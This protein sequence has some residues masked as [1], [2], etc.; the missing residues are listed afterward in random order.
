MFAGEVYG[1]SGC[2]STS[3]FGFPFCMHR[4]ICRSDRGVQRGRSLPVRLNDSDEIVNVL[5]HG[6]FCHLRLARDDRVHD[7][8]M[9]VSERE[10]GS[11][12][13]RDEVEEGRESIVA[14]IKGQ[15][16]DRGQHLV[17]GGFR[18]QAVK[19]DRDR[20]MIRSLG[21]VMDMRICHRAHRNTFLVSRTQCRVPRGLR[22][23]GTAHIQ[24]VNQLVDVNWGRGPNEQGAMFSLSLQD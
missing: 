9:L 17:V 23:N 15:A 19:I 6:S 1:G 18:N 8:P 7:G 13:Y 3:Q 11:R 10:V 24:E 2:L 4:R 22:F 21:N 5:A 20:R 14:W 16:G 12:F